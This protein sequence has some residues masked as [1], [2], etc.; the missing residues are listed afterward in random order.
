MHVD[1]SQNKFKVELIVT[2]YRI[3]VG[4]W[5]EKRNSDQRVQTLYINPSDLMYSLVTTSNHN[6][7]SAIKWISRF[8]TTHTKQ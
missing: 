2:E 1:Q 5:R 7:Y 3:L 4:G 6:V 8:F